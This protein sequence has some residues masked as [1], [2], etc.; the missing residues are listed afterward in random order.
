MQA[1][2]AVEFDLNTQ[3]PARAGLHSADC[4]RC[5]VLRRPV[6]PCQT[7]SWPWRSDAD[8]VYPFGLF[9]QLPASQP[10]CGHLW[11]SAGVM[12][13]PRQALD[14]AAVCTWSS[15]PGVAGPFSVDTSLASVLHD[16][17][18]PGVRPR[19]GSRDC[20]PSSVGCSFVSFQTFPV[21]KNT[22]FKTTFVILSFFFP[23]ILTKILK[24][25]FPCQCHS[26]NHNL[27]SVS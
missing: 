27:N 18:L 25:C 1:R 13:H 4:G 8:L 9:G 17:A 20:L 3:P 19:C 22:F 11:E 2:F 10:R 14:S 6:T 16:A 21:S 7:A 26:H 15:H 24:M 23:I 12:W 5:L